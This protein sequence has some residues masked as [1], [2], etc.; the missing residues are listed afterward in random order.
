MKNLI[1]C[2]MDIGEQMLVNGAE[3]HRVEDSVSR[4]CRSFGAQRAD[5]FII[6]SS[7]LLTVHCSDGSTLT[8]TRRIK[9]LGTDYHKLDL[10][11]RLSRDI[12]SK[13][14]TAE[15]IRAEIDRIANG[16]KYPFGVECLAYA[17]IAGAFT[18]FFGG[19]LKQAAF[20]T[21]IGAVMRFVVLLS[22]ST[23]KNMI[24]SKFICS[25]TLT[26]SAFLLVRFGL[27]GRADEIIIGNIML[28]ISGI[29][30]TNALRDL[31]TGDSITGIL[32]FLEAVLCAAAIAAGYFLLVFVTGGAAV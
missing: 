2:A 23:V 14:M 30:F 3:V 29:G 13:K 20:S 5:V 25:A 9:T 8:Q 17:F 21:L 22:D 26:A 28:L 4:I 6:T 19:S 15:Q 10:L 32:R 12:C 31:F 11:N 24:F 16:K 7:M 1:D 18:L 27:V